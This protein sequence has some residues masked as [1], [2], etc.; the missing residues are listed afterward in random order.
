[1]NVSQNEWEYLQKNVTVMRKRC[2]F[3]KNQTIY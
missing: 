1:V 2:I 3:V